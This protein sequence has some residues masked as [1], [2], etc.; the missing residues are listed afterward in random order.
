MHKMNMQPNERQLIDRWKAQLTS[1]DVASQIEALRQISSHEKVLGL[2]I[3]VVTLAGDPNDDVRM[4]AAEAMESAIQPEP[5]EVSSFIGMMDQSPDGE[6]CY[7]ATT[8]LGRLGI[9][10]TAAVEALESC[11]LYS[12]Y[13]AA[14]ERAVWSLSQIGSQATTA[15]PSLKKIATQS[16]HPRLKRLADEVVRRFTE[17]AQIV[18]RHKRA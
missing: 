13:L 8:M 9:A 4:W 18:S 14:R 6:V 1:G 12:D 5:A 3:Q 17:E 2:A 15:L 10:A 7:W 11:L 16:D